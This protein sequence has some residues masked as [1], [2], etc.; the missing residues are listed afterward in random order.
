[1]LLSLAIFSANVADGNSS[2]HDFPRV[3]RFQFHYF[4]PQLFLKVFF[5]ASRGLNFGITA[6]SNVNFV[7]CYLSQIT[8]QVSASR[9]QQNRARHLMERRETSS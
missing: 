7:V 1:M 8:A 5:N 4:F 3:P 6:N 9:K 2:G